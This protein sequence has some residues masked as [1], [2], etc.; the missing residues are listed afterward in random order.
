LRLAVYQEQNAGNDGAD[1]RDDGKGKA[2]E[3]YPD[4]KQAIQDKENA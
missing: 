4:K 3:I 1:S 2:S